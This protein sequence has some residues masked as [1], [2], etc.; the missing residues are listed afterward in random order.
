MADLTES[1][2]NNHQASDLILAIDDDDPCLAE[3]LRLVDL[4]SVKVRVGK[5]LRLGGTLNAVALEYADQYQYLGFM[6]DDHRPRTLGWD[7][8]YVEALKSH[9]FVYG[10]DLLQGENLPTQAAMRSSVVKTLGYMSP[11]VL[12]HMF[13]DNAWKA[14]GEGVGSIKYLPDVIVEHLHPAAGKALTDH[15]YDEVWEYMDPD[16]K[17]WQEYNDSGDLQADVDKLK[18]LL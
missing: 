11:P 10:N 13:I 5:R 1:F 14:W 9:L 6:G 7:V 12:T 18:E 15:R 4:Y 2:E 17:K 8:Q 3:Y 16:S